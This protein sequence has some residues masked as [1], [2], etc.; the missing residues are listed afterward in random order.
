MLGWL[1]GGIAA[2]DLGIKSEIERQEADTFPR[3]LPWGKGWIRLHKNHNSGFPFGFLKERPEL[4]KGIPA[5][6]V[7]AA[8]GALGVLMLRKGRNTQ[9]LGLA[10]VIGGALSNLYDRVRRGYVVDYFTI[11]WKKLERVVFNLGDLF[12]FLGTLVFMLGELIDSLKELSSS[13]RQGSRPGRR[14]P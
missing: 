3:D 9:K 12:V 1:I 10:L 5:M 8:A 4:V 2:L 11:R 13:S 7:S 6:V 14:R